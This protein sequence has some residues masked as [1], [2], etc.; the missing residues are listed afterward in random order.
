MGLDAALRSPWM[1]VLSD[2]PDTATISAEAIDRALASM[3]ASAQASWPTLD[4]PKEQFFLHVARHLGPGDT[5]GALA[6]VRASDLYLAFSCSLQNA[7]ALSLFDRHYRAELDRAISRIHA[8]GADP[9]DLRQILRQ[10]L[11]VDC[12]GRGPKIGCYSGHG[13]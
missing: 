12:D 9:D 1:D 10:K 7:E 2:R 5:L 8:R 4:V 6:S 11:F 13:G 3:L